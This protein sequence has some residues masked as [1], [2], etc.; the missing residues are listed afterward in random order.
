MSRLLTIP[1]GRTAKFVILAIWLA[2]FI[3]SGAA[4]LPGK[5]ADA[6]NNESTTF[7]PGDA[8]STKV[9]GIA[10][11][12][13]GGEQAPI[14]IIYR[15]E[16][17][18]TADDNAKVAADREELNQA[19]EE[20]EGGFYGPVSP[21]GEP[22]PSESGD[23]ALLVGNVTG[24][25]DGATI[26]DPIDDIRERVSD[27]GGGLEVKVTGPAGFAADAIKVFENINSTLLAVGAGA[28][29]RAARPDLP[30]PGVPVDPAVLRRVRRGRDALASATGSPSWA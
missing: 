29:H 1:A 23:A 19:I 18:L 11:E 28:R 13:Q 27:P 7:L 25:G 9:L 17:G 14:V 6:E 30:Q 5:Y 8:E 21:F 2:V 22:R 10:E 26:L 24:D 4:N 12:L 16:G 15:R 3:G 20:N